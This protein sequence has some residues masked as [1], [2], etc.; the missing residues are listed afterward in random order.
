MRRAIVATATLLIAGIATVEWRHHSMYGHWLGYGWHI[1]VL[2]DHVGD[3][4]VRYLGISNF[5]LLPASIEACI[6]RN[7]RGRSAPV[8]LSRLQTQ[9]K[10][11][12]QPQETDQPGTCSNARQVRLTIWP[13]MSF[14]TK[15]MF[16]GYGRR[17]GELVRIVA[18]SSVD[19]RGRRFVSMPFPI[20]E[21][22]PKHCPDEC[23]TIRSVKFCEPSQNGECRKLEEWRD[24]RGSPHPASVDIL[25][26]LH[27]SATDSFGSDR[28]LILATTKTMIAPTNQ[29][30]LDD[31][32]A[33][34]STLSWGG[35]E[36]V[37]LTIVGPL[38]AGE[39]RIVRIGAFDL[40]ER[41]EFYNGDTGSLWPWWFRAN[42]RVETGDGLKL[43]TGS[44]ELPL[45]PSDR[46]LAGPKNKAMECGEPIQP[47]VIEP[48]PRR[49]W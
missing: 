24:R 27:H 19:E 6:P 11:G 32:Y 12:W 41:I 37:R 35:E 21:D 42:L 33:M 17:R 13:L 49:F 29:Y 36:D 28:L 46:R 4:P 38:A 44:A 2:A 20:P 39:T 8:A 23:I 45:I 30:G 26:E 1:D 34:K 7:D 48:K 43:A 22:V 15:P 16:F 47:T 40:R 31:L 3:T 10:T 18:S 9:E 14:Y 5:G 25:C